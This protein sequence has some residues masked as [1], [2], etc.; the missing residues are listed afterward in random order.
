[1]LFFDRHI[2]KNGGGSL[3]KS[4]QQSNC[5]FVGYSIYK[6]TWKRIKTYIDENKNVCVDGH[7]PVDDKWLSLVRKIDN[8]SV[9]TLRV[10]NPIDHYKSFYRWGVNRKI[11]FHNWFPKNLQTNILLHSHRAVLAS[12]NL[13]L[14]I[15]SKNE[16]DRI[17]KYVSRNVDFFYTTNDIDC[18]WKILRNSTRLSLP[19]FHISEPMRYNKKPS[20]P[21]DMVI[22]EMTHRFAWCDW[23]LYN[24]ALK[25]KKNKCIS[26]KIKTI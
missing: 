25:N 16:C 5:T 20:F 15:I 21:N 18:M 11:D 1:M 19:R 4:M 6:S 8:K 17:I 2:E 13:S 7:S 12:R 23:K 9:I 3:S 14:P 22:E 26:K 24:A 10:R